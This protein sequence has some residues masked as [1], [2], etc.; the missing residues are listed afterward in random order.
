MVIRKGTEI[1]LKKGTFV[2]DKKEVLLKEIDLIQSCINRMAQNSFV[3]KGW[4]ISLVAVVLALMPETISYKIV[5]SLGIIATFCFWYLDAFF[6][7][8]ERL[9]RWKYEW[10]ITNRMQSDE[11]LFNL[12]PKNSNMWPSDKKKEP[13]ILRIMF[14]KTLVPIYLTLVILSMACLIFQILK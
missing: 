3:V 6:L 1:T 5:S 10:V 14:T 8:T 9:Y 4:T 7:K 12:N 13:T 11:Y 2:M